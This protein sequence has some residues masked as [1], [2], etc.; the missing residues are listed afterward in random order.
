MNAKNEN[1]LSLFIGAEQ[2]SGKYEKDVYIIYMLLIKNE[3]YYQLNIKYKELFPQVST[4]AP[5]PKL[6]KDNAYVQSIQAF[7][8]PM[9]TIQAVLK[10]NNF[11][12]KYPSYAM[13]TSTK[14][15]IQKQLANNNQKKQTQEQNNL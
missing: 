1:N 12:K 4:S 6:S 5:L 3:V 2:G 11:G 14:T 13:A 15:Q 10:I 8:N 7:I 9:I